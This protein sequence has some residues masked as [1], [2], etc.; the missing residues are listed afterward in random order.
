MDHTCNNR[1]GFF[2]IFFN[3]NVLAYT[4]GCLA[5]TDSSMF[6]QSEKDF[7]FTS[8]LSSGLIRAGFGVFSILEKNQLLYWMFFEFTYL[9]KRP[10]S[11]RSVLFHWGILL[12]V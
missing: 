10:V 6:F 11:L 2:G 5:V 3:R 4:P 9:Q 7:V 1:F 12:R 8:I